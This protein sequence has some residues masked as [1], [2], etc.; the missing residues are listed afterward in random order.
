M[1][2]SVDQ[3]AKKPRGALRSRLSI[4]FFFALLLFVISGW[5]Y[6]RSVLQ[7]KHEVQLERTNAVNQNIGFALGTVNSYNRVDTESPQRRQE[8]RHINLLTS[9]WLLYKT[10]DYGTSNDNDLSLSLAK[11]SL[12]LLGCSNTKQLRTFVADASSNY[13][14]AEPFAE[15]FIDPKNQEYDQ[16]EEFVSRATQWTPESH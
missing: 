8:V 1:T 4:L 6:E 14:F 9:I 13:G 11:A 2:N 10:Q 7:S 15:P 3:Q 16:L 12:D 5:L